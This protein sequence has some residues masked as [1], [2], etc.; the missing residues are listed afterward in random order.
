MHDDFE[1]RVETTL[2]D[3]V[4]A[5][6]TRQV[7]RERTISIEGPSR[8]P[9]DPVAPKSEALERLKGLRGL[10]NVKRIANSLLAHAIASFRMPDASRVDP[11][12]NFAFMGNPGTGKT[13][14]AREFGVMLHEL[15]L[16]ANNKFVETTGSK[17]LEMD[18]KDIPD[19]LDSA[20]GGVLFID[21]AHN[22][23]PAKDAK[24]KPAVTQILIEAAENK[25][26]ELTIM[27]AGYKDE[28]EK[29]LYGFD[30]GLKSRFRDVE[31]DDFTQPVLQ[32]IFEKMAETSTGSSRT[33]SR[34]SPRAASRAAAAS[35]ASA[36]RATSAPSSSAWWSR[37][38]SLA[39]SASTR[40]R[41]RWRGRLPPPPPL[42]P[43]PRRRAAPPRLAAARR[44]G[45]DRDPRRERGARR[46]PRPARLR[47]EGDDVEGRVLKIDD[48]LLHVRFGGAKGSVF[49]LEAGVVSA[50]PGEVYIEIELKPDASGKL[51]IVHDS[52]LSE[53]DEYAVMKLTPGMAAAADGRLQTGDTVRVVDGICYSRWKDVR[54]LVDT[55][56][57]ASTGWVEDL[58][59]ALRHSDL[60][61]F[62]RAIDKSDGLA[63]TER[64]YNEK[65]DATANKCTNSYFWLQGTGSGSGTPERRQGGDV[66]RRD[67]EGADQEGRLRREARADAQAHRARAR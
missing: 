4:S 36:T 49:L 66:G 27:I 45:G 60:A 41:R 30:V 28:I 53:N 15:G 56:S 2:A 59:E 18:P 1:V 44:R 40:R 32:E 19:L 52:G 51:G 21:E 55:G 57:G 22:L 58:Y 34:S 9:S 13:T 54:E 33:T 63:A 20:M 47:V 46:A 38:P 6:P 25:R 31:L 7:T 23:D 11:V 14:V 10:E 26:T 62:K 61:R 29:K 17:L 24:G 64:I 35:R 65:K 42:P 37:A 67:G 43:P 3:C 8:E 48:E 50:K 5:P 39:S 16:R 12:L